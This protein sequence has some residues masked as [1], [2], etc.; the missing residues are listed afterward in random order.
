MSDIAASHIIRLT[1]VL[2]E[3]GKLLVL[4]QAIWDREWYLPGGKLECVETIKQGIVR[5]IREETGL[6]VKFD[7]VISIS[8]T[9]FLNP[10][11]LNI[12]ISVRRVSGE[13]CIPDREQ[14]S[15]PIKNVI[16]IPIDHI[17]QYGFSHCFGEAC[18]N[19]FQG[20]EFYSGLDTYFDLL[21]K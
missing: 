9:D 2:I 7:R 15:T 21:R 5:E 17:E 14:E 16:Y 10:A 3:N 6:N 19:N 1:G 18:K 11:A 4:E 8:D 12:L 13:T 20:V